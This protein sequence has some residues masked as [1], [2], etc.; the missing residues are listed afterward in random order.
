MNRDAIKPFLAALS[1]PVA[2]IAA[3]AAPAAAAT[4]D[5]SP[6][7]RS[8]VEA[9]SLWRPP[10]PCVAIRAGVYPM[11]AG[12]CPG[13]TGG[14]D[15]SKLEATLGSSGCPAFPRSAEDFVPDSRRMP[16]C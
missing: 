10:M 8:A 3:T 4:A 5:T 14:L 13:T 7:L 15:W 11:G 6:K 2:I 1:I 16:R 12:F 9:V